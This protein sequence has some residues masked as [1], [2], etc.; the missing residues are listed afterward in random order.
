L[1]ARVVADVERFIER[2]CQSIAVTGANA[3]LDARGIDVDP[4]NTAPFN[5]AASGCAPPIPPIPPDT[6][7]L[8]ERSPA[9]LPVSHGG[10]RFERALHDAL[11]ADVDPTAAQSS[12]RTSSSRGVRARE[13]VP[14]W[15]G[16]DEV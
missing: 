12:D 9:N 16:A 11:R 15:P 1:I 6:T 2:H 7:S 5:V 13:S 14:S 3:S 4:R 8:P 10:K